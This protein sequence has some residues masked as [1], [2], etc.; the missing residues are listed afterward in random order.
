[1][2]VIKRTKGKQAYF[3]LQHS[4]RKNGKVV[5]REIYVGKQLPAE[6]EELKK[7]FMEE[8]Y[9]E[10]LFKVLS[11]IKNRFQ[12][13]W[14]KY[15]ESVKEKAMEQIAVAF[16]YNTNAIEGSTITLEETRE[17]LEEAVTPN[18]PLREVQESLAHAKTF[19]GM[20]HKKEALSLALILR[21]HKEIFSASKP[22]IAGCFRDYLVRVGEYRAPDWQDVER[23]MK[24]LLKFYR[25]NLQMNSVELAARMHYRFEKIHPFGDGNGRVGRLLMNYLLWWNKYPMLVIEFKRRRPY[26]R[27]LQRDEAGF[28]NYF[29]KRF[30]AVHKQHLR[31]LISQK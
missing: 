4:F 6:L 22:D 21:W 14:S 28:V 5:S 7:Q 12:E 2:R 20:L 24:D 27:A 3:Y 25:K 15:P 11:R 31:P 16:T 8:C 13:E 1:M 19:S 30:I 9:K 17:L 29:I 10:G 18:R 26:Y 23:L